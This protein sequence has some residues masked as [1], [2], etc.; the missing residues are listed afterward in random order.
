MSFTFPVTNAAVLS[1]S[2]CAKDAIG[3]PDHF[4]SQGSSF[5][6]FFALVSI[7]RM[8]TSKKAG[9]GIPENK[10]KA[11]TESEKVPLHG[12]TACCG[13]TLRRGTGS[14]G[15]RQ[16]RFGSAT[17]LRGTKRRFGILPGVL[18]ASGSAPVQATVSPM[19]VL[20]VLFGLLLNGSSM[21][22][23]CRAL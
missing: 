14:N 15:E 4:C 20:P 21:V 5:R 11:E 19:R 16:A 10:A 6:S 3:V 12:K 22:E 13:I 9:G 7:F 18:E 23:E 1:L 17:R 2:M 8:N